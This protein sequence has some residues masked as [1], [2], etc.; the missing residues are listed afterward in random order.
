M[1]PCDIELDD[2]LG[3]WTYKP[4]AH[5]NAYRAHE[6][7]IYF[8]PQAQEVI[9]PFVHDRATSA[10]LFCAAESDA[11]R[12]LRLH[13]Q[14]T[15]PAGQ[16]NEPGTIRR[17]NP[18]RRPG[19]RCTTSTYHRAI[20][21]TCDR[22]FPRLSTWRSAMTRPPTIGAIASRSKSCGTS[23]SHGARPTASTRSNSATTT[24]PS[25]GRL[26][27]EAAQ[28]TL[29]HASEQITD[30]IYAERD[31]AKVIEIMRKIG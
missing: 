22:T 8:G 3:V 16:S 9:R 6:R 1:R 11:E 31:R 13:A 19:D 12:R 5:R 25:F 27:L 7:V 4:E 21:Y 30:A 29:G 14:R 28:L 2:K 10:Y 24:R 18:R 23:S 15:T 26:G 17:E 20:Q